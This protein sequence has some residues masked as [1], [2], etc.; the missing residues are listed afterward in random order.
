MNIGKIF[1]KLLN[2]HFP[3]NNSLH[4]VFNRNTV[5]LSYSYT[6]NISS[7]ISSH[8]KFLLNK[9]TD[10]FGCNC[11]QKTSYPLDNKCLT[12]KV[13][14]KA[15]ITNEVNQEKKIYIGLT[16]TTFK[17][18]YRNHVKSFKNKK[19]SKDTE[20]SKYIWS[21]KDK[22]KTP[23][24]KWSVMK[25]IKSSLRSSTC[26]LCLTEKLF[27][28]NHFNDAN[29]LNKRTEFVSKCPHQTKFL[30]SNVKNDSMD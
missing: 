4:K 21:L 28:I 11:R 9:N 2:K 18:C 5:K 20:L 27:I 14:Y 12:P 24:L 22:K 15:E 16:E 19:Y 10:T 3:V 29:L 30:L 23:T 13:V 8:N 26:P 1:F 17:E 6:R 25:S 7:V